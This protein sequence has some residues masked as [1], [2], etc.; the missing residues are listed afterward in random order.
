MCL[1]TT[2]S[3][4]AFSGAGVRPVHDEMTRL[5]SS[6]RVIDD[7]RD[8]LRSTSYQRDVPE[9]EAL[10]IRASK[11][12]GRELARFSLG[13][14]IQEAFIMTKTTLLALG[15]ALAI[16]PTQLPSTSYTNRLTAPAWAEE[17]ADDARPSVLDQGNSSGDLR[18]TQNIRKALVGDEALSTDAK[19][20]KVITIDQVVTLRGEV[21]T[22]KERETIVALATATP[23]V[24]RVEDQLEIDPDTD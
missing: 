15:A 6:T 3:A 9:L 18:I 24:K 14:C 17:H 21:E 23:G 11:I 1:V 8:I 20:V 4:G 22:A 16:A 2:G 13:L 7:M 10:G 5:T 12:R 19:N